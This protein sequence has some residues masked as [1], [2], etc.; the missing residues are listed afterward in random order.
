MDQLHATIMDHGFKLITKGAIPPPIQ[1]YPLSINLADLSVFSRATSQLSSH[2]NEG[3]SSPGIP[4]LSVLGSFADSAETEDNGDGDGDTDSLFGDG[5]T[6]SIAEPEVELES[7][8]GKM[9]H[10][11]AVARSPVVLAP[12]Y[13]SSATGAG[14]DFV[15][16]NSTLYFGPS[17]SFNPTL[18]FEFDSLLPSLDEFNFD[19]GMDLFPPRHCYA[20]PVEI[21]ILGFLLLLTIRNRR[22]GHATS[23]N[24]MRLASIDC[25]RLPIKLCTGASH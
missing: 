23:P 11:G 25:L 20:Y 7:R 22:F 5:D 10:V 9:Q 4:V 14:T 15:I 1:A 19:L 21:L 18:M 8:V 24:E 13:L 17:A 6:V 16:P 12:A 2:A 3:L